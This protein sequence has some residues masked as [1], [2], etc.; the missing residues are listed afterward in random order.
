MT[1]AKGQWYQRK[2]APDQFYMVSYFLPNGYIKLYPY[3]NPYVPLYVTAN[4]IQTKFWY[5]NGYP[6][7]LLF[8]GKVA[9]KS[10]MGLK[11]I[12]L[13]PEIWGELKAKS[14]VAHAH[15][16]V[17]NEL[18]GRNWAHSH[19]PRSRIYLTYPQAVGKLHSTSSAQGK[20]SSTH[21]LGAHIAGNAR[22]VHAQAS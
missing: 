1:I 12:I 5:Y 17:F 11:E 2:V 10:G 13:P 16:M 21:R 18:R 19:V 15:C 4:D 22:V 6:E 3:S 7:N 14:S 8:D 9:G 20:I